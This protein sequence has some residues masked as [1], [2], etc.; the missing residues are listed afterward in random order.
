MRFLIS[1]RVNG[2]RRSKFKSV[3]FCR[4]LIQVKSAGLR[5]V[6]IPLRALRL[7]EVF[8]PALN[9]AKKKPRKRGFLYQ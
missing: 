6:T 9:P 7:D 1:D 2:S 4:G 8:L 3:V 5:V